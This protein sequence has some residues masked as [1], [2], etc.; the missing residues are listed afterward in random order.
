LPVVAAAGLGGV[1]HGG[2]HGDGVNGDQ[3]A[4]AFSERLGFERHDSTTSFVGGASL[5]RQP[6]KF[7][8]PSNYER[9][10][11]WFFTGGDLVT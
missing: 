11:T 7:R 5:P 4:V 8:R 6:C 3:S 10:L 9:P 1:A 2:A